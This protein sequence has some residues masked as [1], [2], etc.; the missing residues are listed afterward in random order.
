M[1]RNILNESY[2][3]NISIKKKTDKIAEE[4]Y[5]IKDEIIKSKLFNLAV[6]LCNQ[7]IYDYIYIFT[8]DDLYFVSEYNI[9]IHKLLEVCIEDAKIMYKRENRN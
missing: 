5:G 3:Y 4:E 9:N 7:M 1:K 8:K 6:N 2:D